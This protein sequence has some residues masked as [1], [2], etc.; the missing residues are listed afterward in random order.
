MIVI[1]NTDEDDLYLYKKN[2]QEEN[3]A[4]RGQRLILFPLRQDLDSRRLV[5]FFPLK[6]RLGELPGC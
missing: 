1:D 3:C 5:L 4:V 6:R 2:I